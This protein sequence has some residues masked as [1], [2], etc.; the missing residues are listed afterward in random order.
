M[1]SVLFFL[2]FLALLSFLVLCVS[3]LIQ[4]VKNFSHTQNNQYNIEGEKQSQ[5]ADTNWLQDLL[6]S[7]SNQDSVGLTKEQT[8]GS[9]E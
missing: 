9:V 2:E 3:H 8:T 7:Y 5:G 6:W 1:S 4:M